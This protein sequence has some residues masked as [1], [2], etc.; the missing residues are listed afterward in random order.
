MDALAFL[1]TR[2]RMCKSYTVCNECPLK[3]NNCGLSASMSDEEYEKVITAVE[4]WAKEHPPKTRQS[5][6][7][8][9]FPN[10]GL[11]NKGI[12]IIDPCDI[13]N[14]ITESENCYAFHCPDCRHEFW[15][16]EVE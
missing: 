16:Q 4:H 3:K 8:K 6:F 11:D 10:A 2:K 9:Q 15:M 14:T 7:L 5:E 1:K 12:I 13:D